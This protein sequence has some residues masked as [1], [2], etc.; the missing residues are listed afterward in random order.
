MDYLKNYYYAFHPIGILLTIS[1]IRYLLGNSGALNTERIIIC[2]V[3]GFLIGTVGN[4]W[5]I[6]QKK[7]R[8]ILH[9]PE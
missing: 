2:I 7:K 3:G 6:Y 1:V 8:Q 5:T 4:L 9:E